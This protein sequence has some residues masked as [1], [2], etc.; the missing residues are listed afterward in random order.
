MRANYAAKIS[1]A[2][3]L[4]SALVGIVAAAGAHAGILVC[5]ISAIGGFVLGFCMGA[6]SIG[7]SGLFL[8]CPEQGGRFLV[9]LAALAGYF[10]VPLIFLG[11]SCVVTV[12][13]LKWIL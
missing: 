3:P 13:G 12:L 8:T 9:M 2:M 11:A 10:V 1:L 4:V 6:L 5:I 7:L